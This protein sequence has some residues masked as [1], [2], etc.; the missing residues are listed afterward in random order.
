[1]L[2]GRRSPD[3]LHVTGDR[4]LFSALHAG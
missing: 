3:V 4:R 2:M 1:V